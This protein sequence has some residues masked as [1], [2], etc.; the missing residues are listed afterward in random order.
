[1]MRQYFADA[2]AAA[3]AAASMLLLRLGLVVVGDATGTDAGALPR[4]H[5]DVSKTCLAAA[6][7][8][9]TATTTSEIYYHP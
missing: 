3:A 4:I 9:T 7:T 5:D 8:E 1:M 6:A 2:A